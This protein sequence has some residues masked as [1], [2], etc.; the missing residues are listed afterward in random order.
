M[1]TFTTAYTHASATDKLKQEG[2]SIIVDLAVN[3][4]FSAK[5]LHFLEAAIQETPLNVSEGTQLK[6]PEE[7]TQ[8]LYKAVEDKQSN[9]SE[10]TVQALAAFA[11]DHSDVLPSNAKARIDEATTAGRINLSPELTLALN[12]AVE[13]G[14]P[15]ALVLR[16][17]AEYAPFENQL[18][19]SGVSEETIRGIVSITGKNPVF[20]SGESDPVSLQASL[21]KEN[22]DSLAALWPESK[23]AGTPEALAAEIETAHRKMIKAIHN[24][25]STRLEITQTSGIF[26]IY[27]APPKNLDEDAD[28]EKLPAKPYIE[29]AAIQINCTPKGLEIDFHNALVENDAKET[30]EGKFT[31]QQKQLALTMLRDAAAGYFADHLDNH[32][33]KGVNPLSIQPDSK[34]GTVFIGES[35]THANVMEH[36]LELL[37][38]R[39]VDTI[40]NDMQRI[41]QKDIAQAVEAR[42]TVPK[43]FGEPEKQLTEH[44]G[45]NGHVVTR[46]SGSLALV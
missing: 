9:L 45:T 44:A 38:T 1:P 2:T 31:A 13:T 19:D 23:K 28:P 46:E 12:T 10:A 35:P 34:S 22:Q 24:A 42:L 41:S 39:R 6:L 29:P 4:P 3:P 16:S 26:T 5:M 8:L 32:T 40:H 15:E 27:E 14:K 30:E 20:R 36:I 33:V 21:S 43:E 25:L 7:I 11:Q 18:R 37:E 17:E